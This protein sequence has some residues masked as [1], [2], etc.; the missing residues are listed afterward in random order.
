MKAPGLL[1]RCT[2]DLTSLFMETLLCTLSW[3]QG[4]DIYTDLL[5]TP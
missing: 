2:F 5:S 1:Q 3:D 4:V